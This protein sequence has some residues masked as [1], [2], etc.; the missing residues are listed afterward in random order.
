M[1]VEVRLRAVEPAD[2]EVFFEHE[3]QPEAQRRAN[4]RARDRPAFFEHW[5]ERILGDDRV[6][7]RTVLA[8]GEVAGGVVSW[9]QDGLR[10]VGYWLG[11]DFWGRGVGT[12]ALTRYLQIEPIRPLRATVDAGNTASLRLLRRCGFTEVDTVHEAAVTFV[13]LELP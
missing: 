13:V 11:Q 3:Q 9:W 10:E 7:A 2:L 6:G 4:F 12:G 5:T 1:S 8:D